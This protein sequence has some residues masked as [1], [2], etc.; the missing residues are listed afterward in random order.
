MEEY[1]SSASDISLDNKITAVSDTSCPEKWIVGEAFCLK[2]SVKRQKKS[3][4][5][6]LSQDSCMAHM[7]L[8]IKKPDIC[9]ARASMTGSITSISSSVPSSLRYCLISSKALVLN[10]PR[11]ICDIG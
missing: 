7:N 4:T 10:V 1:I 5:Q 11:G 6:T 9:A 3:H 2:I 8:G